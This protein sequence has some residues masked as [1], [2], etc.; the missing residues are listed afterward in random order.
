MKRLHQGIGLLLLGLSWSAWAADYRIA[1]TVNQVDT[2]QEAPSVH[3]DFIEYQLSPA[4][5]T[6]TL[7]PIGEKGPQLQPGM[8]VGINTGLDDNGQLVITDLWMLPNEE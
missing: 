2:E 6:H 8:R 1:G 4:V 5:K 7:F 3:I